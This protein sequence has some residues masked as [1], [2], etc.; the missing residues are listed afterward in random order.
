M[1]PTLYLYGMAVVSTAT[2]GNLGTTTTTYEF[3][4]SKFLTYVEKISI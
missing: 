1:Q 2:L 4:Y 3:I